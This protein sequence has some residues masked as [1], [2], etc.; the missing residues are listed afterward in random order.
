MVINT[1]KVKCKLN[2]I[3]FQRTTTGLIIRKRG[4]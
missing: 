4:V 1:T 2:Q 3:K